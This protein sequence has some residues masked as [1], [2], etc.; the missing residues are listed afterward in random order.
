MLKETYSGVELPVVNGQQ[1]HLG[2]LIAAIKEHIS[3]TRSYNVSSIKSLNLAENDIICT[4]EYYSGTG[5]GGR[6]FIYTSQGS[7]GLQDRCERQ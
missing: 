3:G 1:G 2:K 7:T 4:K 5:F 6:N